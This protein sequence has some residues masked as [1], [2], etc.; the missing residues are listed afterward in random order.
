MGLHHKAYITLTEC[1]EQ[2]PVEILNDQA[3]V[4]YLLESVKTIDPSVLAA[5]AAVHQ[6]DA[7][8]RINFEIAFT[9]LAPSCPVLAKVKKEGRVFLR[10]MSLILGLNPTRVVWME[11]MRNLGREQPGLPFVTTGSKNTRT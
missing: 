4:I 8:K 2:I 1:A 5:M 7:D 6:D 10:P 9:F 11:I 3:Q